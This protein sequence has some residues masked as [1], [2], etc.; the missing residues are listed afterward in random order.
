[1]RKRKH[2]TNIVTAT[3]D[4]LIDILKALRIRLEIILD[5]HV[6]DSM[7]DPLRDLDHTIESL[8]E[9]AD[10]IRDGKGSAGERMQGQVKNDRS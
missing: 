5:E 1:M 7:F 9:F 10:E 6:F 3:P 2:R 4:E 8:L